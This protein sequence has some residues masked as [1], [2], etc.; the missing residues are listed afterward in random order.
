MSPNAKKDWNSWWKGREKDYEN[1]IVLPVPS[2]DVYP[3]GIGGKEKRKEMKREVI[4]D[5]A[6]SYVSRL[7]EENE[8]P[9]D[10]RE[11]EIDVEEAFIDGANW[12]INSVWNKDIQ[13]RKTKKPILVK[14]DNGLFNL[15]EDIR[16][17]KGI[18]D[19]VSIFAYIEDLLPIKE[20]NV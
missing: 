4:I 2:S 11:I 19:K 17:L 16:D 15:F 6:Q 10:T 5:I 3:A 20:D 7:Y 9:N 1:E 8:Y 12:R 13:N 14:F 18:E